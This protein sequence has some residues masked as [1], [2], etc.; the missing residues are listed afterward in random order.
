[1]GL[2]EISR[3]RFK[4][5][6]NSMLIPLSYVLGCFVNFWVVFG[7]IWEEIIFLISNPINSHS[8]KL[9]PMKQKPNGKVQSDA[10]SV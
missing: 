6:K 9:S 5:Y 8:S 1:M 4:Q 3:S 7:S 2:I 10:K